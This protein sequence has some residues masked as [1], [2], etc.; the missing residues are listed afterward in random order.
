MVPLCRAPVR[1]AL[2][3]PANGHARFAQ[4][5]ADGRPH[6]GIR[7]QI[8]IKK[9]ELIAH[10]IFDHL[11]Y[12]YIKKVAKIIEKAFSKQSPSVWNGCGWLFSSFF[13]IFHVLN[14]IK[15]QY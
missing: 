8:N 3:L 15:T 7:S 14:C 6:A 2:P 9:Q 10:F 4:G 1:S 13:N 5:V 12:F 11:A